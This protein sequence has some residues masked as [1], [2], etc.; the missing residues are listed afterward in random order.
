[1]YHTRF[2]HYFH[3]LPG[4]FMGSHDL[5]LTLIFKRDSHS[6][7]DS[8]RDSKRDACTSCGNIFNFF[9]SSIRDTFETITQCLFLGIFKRK[10]LCLKGSLLCLIVG[11]G[12][13]KCFGGE[14]GLSRFLKMVGG[15][16][17]VLGHS[18]IIIT[19][20]WGVS[21]PPH[22]PLSP[23]PLQLRTKEYSHVNYI[24]NI[25]SLQHK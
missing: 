17:T 13:I 11:W 3:S 22:P 9:W 24:I 6:R 10:C 25:R 20:T 21:S 15:G 1:M 19:W 18:L 5:R 23:L 12:R 7:T 16:G 4:H 14:G 2:T 8:K